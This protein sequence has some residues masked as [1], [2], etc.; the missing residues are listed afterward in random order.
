MESIENSYGRLLLESQLPDSARQLAQP[1]KS[2]VISRGKND[3]STLSL[4]A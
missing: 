2:V 1:L 3:L 4:S